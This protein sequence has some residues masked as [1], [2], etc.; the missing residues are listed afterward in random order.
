MALSEF[1]I[2][3]LAVAFCLQLLKSKYRPH[4]KAIPGPFLASFSNLWRVAAVYVEDMPGWA[5]QAHK[6]YGQVVRIGP[7]HISFASP[8]AFQS[9]Y[10]S[11]Q[12]F[13]KVTRSPTL[14]D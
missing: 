10:L 14:G 4:L 3:A 2:G 13:P 7:N 6:K 5:A 12:A 11:R 9:I 8:S 1:V